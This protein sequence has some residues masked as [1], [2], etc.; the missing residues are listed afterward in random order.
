MLSVHNLGSS[1]FRFLL[2]SLEESEFHGTCGTLTHP[3]F[4][5]IPLTLFSGT[6]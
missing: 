1:Y 4:H 3:K 2:G 6:L 5:F